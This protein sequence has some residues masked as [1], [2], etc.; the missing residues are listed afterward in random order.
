ML[1]TFALAGS[2]NLWSWARRGDRLP[3]YI[4]A[5]A[6]GGAVL[7]AALGL[8]ESARPDGGALGVLVLIALPPTV[9][10]LTFGVF[11]NHV[12]ENRGT[13]DSSHGAV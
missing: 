13:S 8:I 12:I 6:L 2:V 7:G 10:Y 1:I 9:V 5:M 3:R 4:H 11:G